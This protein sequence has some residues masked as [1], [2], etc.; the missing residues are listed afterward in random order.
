MILF[1]VSSAFAGDLEMLV[2]VESATGTILS[3]A[4]ICLESRNSLFLPATEMAQILGE[5]VHE[6]SPESL[7]FQVGENTEK[8]TFA[9]CK[10]QQIESCP[11]L[12]IRNKRLYMRIET[13]KDRLHWPLKFEPRR[14]VISVDAIGLK[15]KENQSAARDQIDLSKFKITRDMISTPQ[16][17]LSHNYESKSSQNTSSVVSNSMLFEH[18]LWVQGQIISAENQEQ[19]SSFNANLSKKSFMQDLLGPMKAR[20]YELLKIQSPDFPYIARS[21]SV[22]GLSISNQAQFSTG[23]T[24]IFTRKI[25]RGRARPQSRVELYLNGVFIAETFV[26]Q[27]YEYEFLDVP[28]Y[29]G[30]N[31]F[32]LILTSPL[33]QKEIREEVYRIGSHELRPSEFGYEISVGDAGQYHRQ[34]VSLGYGLSDSIQAKMAISEAQDPGLNLQKFYQPGLT[35]L[36][37]NLEVSF[38]TIIDQKSGWAYLLSPQY[39]WGTSL[40]NAELVKFDSFQSLAVNQNADDDQSS[41]VHVSN[42]TPFSF[43]NFES[44][45]VLLSRY[46]EKN[47]RFSERQQ[48]L[49]VRG[50]TRIEKNSWSLEAK[51]NLKPSPLYDLSF[52]WGVYELTDRKRLSFHLNNENQQGVFAEYEKLLND[53]NVLGLGVSSESSRSSVATGRVKWS[54]DWR[55][56]ESEVRLELGKEFYCGLQLSTLWLQ[57]PRNLSH[58]LVS[59]G[60]TSAANLRIRIF[61][62]ENNNGVFDVGENTPAKIKVRTNDTQREYET[63]EN[64]IV[65]I[66]N[67]D[68]LRPQTVEV[69]LESIPNIFLTPKIKKIDLALAP[70]QT[71]EKEI[72]LVSKFDLKGFVSLKSWQKLIPIELLD[73]SHQVVAESTTRSNGEFRF[74]DLPPGRYKIKIKDVFA[75]QLQL[76]EQNKTQEVELKGIGG[77]VRLSPMGDAK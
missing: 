68:F 25:L 42:I 17:Q 36:H 20:Q 10:T 49:I 11:D 73:E 75:D 77:L 14:L 24:A 7:Q 62:D 22:W 23:A 35:F 40:W 72:P 4:L 34:S 12:M 18:D 19:E 41:E 76:T 44:P 56:F 54:H 66:S 63:D 58:I 64:G 47:Y 30:Q 71:L 43:E 37:E 9:E 8:L 31:Q 5:Q 61:V 32:Q 6:L 74:Y 55:S 38:S 48:E 59:R 57:E 33:G 69:I 28:L 67:L 27:N 46:N 70:A 15:S 65:A 50:I 45:L 21:K 3:D 52:D 1:L 39:Q 13:A 53:Q 29:F 51:H 2:Q 26:N 16:V 60:Q